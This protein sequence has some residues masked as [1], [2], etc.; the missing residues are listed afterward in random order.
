[1][2][3]TTT[4]ARA[5]SKRPQAAGDFPDFTNGAEFD[6]L[7][8]ADKE[9]V[10]R[11]YEQ[12]KH[13]SEMRPLNAR[14]RAE[15]KREQKAGRAGRPVIGEGSTQIAVTIETGLLRQ[16]DEYAKAHGLKRTQLI[17]KGLRAIIGKP[18]KQSA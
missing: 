16:V 8:D 4:N 15:V 14:E 11:Y 13:L 9:K 10:S 7:S 1:M 2:I 18:R 12:G 6:A 17:A 3:K 5:K